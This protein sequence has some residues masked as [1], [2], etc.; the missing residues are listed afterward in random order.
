MN[1]TDTYMNIRVMRFVDGNMHLE[2]SQTMGRIYTNDKDILYPYYQFFLYLLAPP[3]SEHII[4]KTSEN[5]ATS[6]DDALD[7]IY[8]LLMMSSD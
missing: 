1:L 5:M 6:I 7:T 4:F 8:K 2:Y 3:A